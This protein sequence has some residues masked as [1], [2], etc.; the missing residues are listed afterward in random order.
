M[1]GIPCT[2]VFTL[3]DGAVLAGENYANPS[4][5][6]QSTRESPTLP[7]NVDTLVFPYACL[8][9]Y[10]DIYNY[11][12]SRVHTTDGDLSPEPSN[13][14]EGM[15]LATSMVGADLKKPG[16][17]QEFGVV[18]ASVTQSISPGKLWLH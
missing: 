12:F 1:H 15:V 3:V 2:I 7:V 6:R 13:S 18:P 14:T 11:L 17:D 8:H 5:S 4:I 9:F 10:F 16:Q